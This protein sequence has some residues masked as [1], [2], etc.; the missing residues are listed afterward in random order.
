MNNAVFAAL[1]VYN[2][3]KF[4]HPL[5]QNNKYKVWANYQLNIAD[6]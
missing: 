4:N 6:A 1:F 2:L 5:R 3:Q